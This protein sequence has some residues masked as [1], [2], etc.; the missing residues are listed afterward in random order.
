MT[1]F[2]YEVEKQ[3]AVLSDTGSTTLELNVIRWN[4]QQAGKFDLRNWGT[5]KDGER[6]AYKGITL[7]KAQAEALYLA[8]K[9]V[10][11]QA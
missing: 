3:I 8:L 6:T 10:F 7:D 11:E 9:G 4:G 5:D 1:K 2:H